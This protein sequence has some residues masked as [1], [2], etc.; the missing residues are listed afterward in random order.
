MKWYASVCLSEIVLNR[1]CFLAALTVFLAAMQE[2]T[3]NIHDKNVNCCQSDWPGHLL[4]VSIM[5]VYVL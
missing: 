1:R 2:V 5:A 3:N 4:C